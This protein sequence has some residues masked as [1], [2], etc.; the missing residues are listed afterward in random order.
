MLDL[1]KSINEY[2]WNI[3]LIGLGI[4]LFIALFGT[5]TSAIIAAIGFLFRFLFRR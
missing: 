2:I 4:P 1:I 3:I 5:G